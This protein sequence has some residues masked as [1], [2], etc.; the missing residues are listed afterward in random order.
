MQNFTPSERPLQL[1]RSAAPAKAM[2]EP[3]AELLR[4]CAD[5]IAV[6]AR[7]I[8]WD[9][10]ISLLDEEAG[11]ALYAQRDRMMPLI[12]KITATTA[13]GRRAKAAAAFGAMRNVEEIVSDH[14]YLMVRSAMADMIAGGVA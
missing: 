11:L 3:D 13:A 8:A 2:S 1:W 9:K 10:D 14:L 4:L 12:T 5:F 7:L 6:D